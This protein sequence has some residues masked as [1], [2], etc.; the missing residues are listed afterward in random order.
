[1]ESSPANHAGPKG[2]QSP[3]PSFFERLSGMRNKNP[4]EM[5]ISGPILQD[6]HAM[7]SD[8]WW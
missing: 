7:S 2:G 8:F 3:R 6:E 4:N 1:M 5:E